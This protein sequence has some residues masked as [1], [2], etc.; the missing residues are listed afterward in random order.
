MTT[1]INKEQR[2]LETKLMGM[3]NSLRGNT[4]ANE[5]KDYI[6]GT[7]FYY[8]LSKKT[9]KFVN[10]CLKND[11]LTYV[12]AWENEEIR[13]TLIEESISCLGWLIEPQYMFAE[14]ANR[15]ATNKFDVEFMQDAINSLVDST[16][17]AKSENAFVGLFDDMRLDSIKLGKTVKERSEVMAKIVAILNDISI[18]IDDSEMDILGNAYEFLIGYFAANAGKKAGEFYTPAGPAKLLCELTTDGL[19]EVE[20]VCD[21]TCG[22]GSLLLRLKQYAN[23]HNI[24][25]CEINP[26]TYN[27]CRMNMILRD[28]S[29]TD[30]SIKNQDTLAK[31]PFEANAKYKVQVANPPYSL[32]WN[33]SASET[34]DRFAK[35]GKMAPKNKADF[36]FVQHMI[37]HMDENDGRF[38]VLLPSGILFRGGAEETIRKFIIDNLNILDTVIS[39]PANLFYGTSIPVCVFVCKKNRGENNGNVLFIDASKNFEAGKNQNFLTDENVATIM[40]A[41]KNRKDVDKFARVVSIEEIR[42]NDYNCNVSR[43]VD[44]FE[45]EE[46]ID[47]NAETRKI[48]ELDAQIEKVEA[49]I[50]DCFIQLGLEV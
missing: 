11:G 33:P 17:G 31:D 26:T 42:E 28:I 22:S 14:M 27:L 3:A 12:Q 40:D 15:V 1:I 47:I 25:G 9:E 38:A 16:R 29:Y 18:D 13:Q 34:D 10:D 4:S 23:I 5:F 2:E 44:T 19:T 41:Y 48:K 36:A 46:E 43:Y 24:N 7:L 6:L 20:S 35:Y 8:Y 30:F 37:H 39:L 21:P 32:E 45:A 49:Q 50:R